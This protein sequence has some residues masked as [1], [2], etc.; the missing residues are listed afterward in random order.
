MWLAPDNAGNHGRYASAL[1]T[2]DRALHEPAGHTSALLAAAEEPASPDYARAVAAMETWPPHRW[3]ELD[4]SRLDAWSWYGGELAPRRGWPAVLER[5]DAPI[6]LL[7]LAST[8]RD[9]SLRERATRALA[10]HAGPL[11][12]AAL[13]VRAVDRVPEVR[14]V[15]RQ[16]LNGRREVSDA[17]AVVPILL[18][19][20]QREA[21]A[22]VLE[23]YLERLAPETLR[24]LVS[25]QDRETRRLAAEGAPFSSP[26]LVRVAASDPDIQTCLIAARRAIS[27]D[28]A[29]AGRPNAEQAAQLRDWLVRPRLPRDLE[30]LV[31]FHAGL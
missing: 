24:S 1:T 19:A 2:L 16:A 15:A 29:A 31:R 6:L 9:G 5:R 25:S 27:Q 23:R 8:H 18:A 22:G 30:R 3:L 4:A 11:A 7:V 14:E 28:R 13:A 10:G 12:S 17:G 21:A 20:R 26:E